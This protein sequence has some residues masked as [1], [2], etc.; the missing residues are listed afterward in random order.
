MERGV[1]IKD[2]QVIVFQ[3]DHAV[4][5]SHALVQIS[6]RVGRK[7]DAPEGNVYFICEEITKHIKTAVNDIKRSNEIGIYKKDL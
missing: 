4:Y 5:D 1:T 7:S 6:G 2:V 3:A